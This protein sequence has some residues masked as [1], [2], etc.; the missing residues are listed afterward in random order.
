MTKSILF[1]GV[2][3]IAALAGFNGSIGTGVE[4]DLSGSTTA[5]I[6]DESR[7]RAAATTTTT[8]ETIE[9]TTTTT[10]TTTSGTIPPIN[11]GG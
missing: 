8:T 3:V 10:T 5:V 4:S 9:E 6:S 7:N 2:L 11:F 1:G